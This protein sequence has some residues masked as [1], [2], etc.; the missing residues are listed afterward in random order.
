LPIEALGIENVGT[1]QGPP[2]S[3]DKAKIEPYDE[4]N[5]ESSGERRRPESLLVPVAEADPDR[6]D[7]DQQAVKEK[8]TGT[9]DDESLKRA[10]LIG[11]RCRGIIP[12]LPSVLRE[13]L[14]LVLDL[15]VLPDLP[16]YHL[17]S[18]EDVE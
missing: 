6:G 2:D 10:F 4:S 18:V 14:H 7:A 1:S 11:K 9:K 12:C 3:E 17:G 13:E 5:K 15:L 16:F 8:E